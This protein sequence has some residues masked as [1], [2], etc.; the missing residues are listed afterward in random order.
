MSA[1]LDGSIVV[2]P[3]HGRVQVMVDGGKDYIVSY[4]HTIPDLY[5]ALVLKMTS[6]IDKDIFPYGDVLPKVRIERGK[7]PERIIHV[8]PG[9]SSHD[10]PQLPRRMVFCIK[11]HPNTDSL[12]KKFIGTGVP[13]GIFFRA[14]PK[15]VYH[16]LYGHGLHLLFSLPVRFFWLPN[17]IQTGL[18]KSNFMFI[19]FPPGFSFSF[20]RQR[21]RSVSVRY[22]PD[23]AGIPCALAHSIKQVNQ[24]IKYIYQMY[25]HT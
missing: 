6:R 19:I 16:I 3:V 1:D 21:S 7:Q 13:F 9:K 23:S 18:L 11:L 12:L 15:P 20:C 22:A 25:I 4:Q 5:P 17:R 14:F 8:L 24:N 10:L 2:F